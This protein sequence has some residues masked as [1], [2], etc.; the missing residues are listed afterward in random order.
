MLG[1]S[2]EQIPRF[3]QQYVR[4]DELI[5]AAAERF[6]SE[7]RERQFPQARHCFGMAKE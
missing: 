7:V 1:L 6:A 4:V 3:A 2:G 5:G